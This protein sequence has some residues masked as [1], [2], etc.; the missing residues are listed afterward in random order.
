MKYVGK[1]LLPCLSLLCGLLAS[2]LALSVTYAPDL[3]QSEWV[4]EGSV[5][6]C[7]LSHHIPY[8]GD[9]VF[10]RQ[11]GELQEFYLD[12]KTSRLKAGKASVM[13]E[14]PMWKP[15]KKARSLGL[16]PV[17]QGRRPVGLGRKLSQQILAE[18]H[19]GMQVV[20]TRQPWYGA[21]ES[22]RVAMAPVNFRPA[23]RQYLDCLTS[24][25]P[26]NFEQ[27]S[28]TPIYFSSG[29]EEL[30]ASEKRKLDNVVLYVNADPSVTVFYIDGH[31]DSRGD[32]AENLE[33]SKMRAEIVA[34][35][36]ASRGVDTSKIQT[37]WHGE[38]YPV[39]S[40]RSHSGRAKNRRVTIRLE[41]GEAPTLPSRDPEMAQTM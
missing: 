13:A 37:R 11:A 33:L 4:A 29:Q 17:N 39:A 21:E 32:R 35:Y 25:L 40:N 10:Y 2:G 15:K 14:S 30:R 5:F 19:Q 26:V 38:R 3:D 12:A 8:Y 1:C 27:I 16:V 7:K 6:E 22:L 23:Y 41:K 28:R 34:S 20:L 9:A 18:L 31:T 36:L 24:L